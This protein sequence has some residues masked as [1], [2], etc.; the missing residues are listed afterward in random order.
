MKIANSK[1]TSQG[2]ISVPREVRRRLGLV[3]GTSIEWHESGN[4]I[5]VHRAGKYTSEEIHQA[6]FPAQPHK[7]SLKE[8]K[9]GIEEY[10][11]SKH[12]RR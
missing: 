11:R 4:D 6:M 1:L 3:P 9:A 2:Q 8:M 10:I 12:A 7:R 5:T